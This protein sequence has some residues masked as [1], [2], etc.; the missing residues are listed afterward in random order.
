MFEYFAG[1][2]PRR[3]DS[4]LHMLPLS[5]RSTLNMVNEYRSKYVTRKDTSDNYTA[6]KLSST[7]RLHFITVNS[8]VNYNI[9]FSKR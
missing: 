1:V 2:D 8:F 3:V 7:L 6:R 5:Y 4:T 9:F